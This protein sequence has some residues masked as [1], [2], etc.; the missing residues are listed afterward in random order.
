MASNL[1][2]NGDVDPQRFD[3]LGGELDRLG[4]NYSLELYDGD[5]TLVR[6]IQV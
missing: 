4:L 3:E 5:D 6:E 1:L 2:L